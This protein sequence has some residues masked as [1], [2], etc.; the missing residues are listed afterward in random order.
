MAQKSNTFDSYDQSNMIRED[1]SD[2]ITNIDPESVPLTTR[3]RKTK[4]SNTLVEWLTETLRASADNAHLEGDETTA[5]AKTQATRLT[6][7]T[8][9]IKDACLISDTDAGLDY[10]GKQRAMA[11][12]VLKMGKELRLD[13]ERA[14][15]LNQPS[16]AGNA[17]T[18]RKLAGLGAWIKTN[19]GNVGT[20]GAAPTGDGSDARTDGSQTVFAQADFDSVM[21]SIWTEGGAPNTVYLSPFQM[22]KALGFTGNNNQ[23]ANVVASEER[24]VN[25]LSIYLTPW[26]QVTFQPSRENRSRDV[27]ILQDDMFEIAELRPYKN[28]ELAKTGDATMRQ[29]TYEATLCVKSEKSSGIVADCTTS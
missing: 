25:S 2:I 19:Q 22:N 7:R 5:S 14:L 18:A 15:F 8:Q 26:G 11:H 28:V 4:A 23:R 13:F 27:F 12:E 9:I 10:A 3:C 21:Q 24:V 29:I 20:G 16:V 6:N 17:T 1:L